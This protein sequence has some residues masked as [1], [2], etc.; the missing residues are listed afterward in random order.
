MVRELPCQHIFHPECV[1]AFLSTS[2]S[3]CPMCKKSALPRGYCPAIITNA[4]VRRERVV[5]RIRERV[6][7]PDHDNG[8]NDPLDPRTSAAHLSRSNNTTFSGFYGRLQHFRH[9]SHTQHRTNPDLTSEFGQPMTDILPAPSH[10]S[11][12]DPLSSP[13]SPPPS[14]LPPNNN[15]NNNN[16][17]RERA[18][19]RALAMLGPQPAPLDPDAEEARRTPAWKRTVRKVFPVGR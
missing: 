4:M 8:F 18:R 9:H 12:P 16:N 15:N 5:R 10:P 7:G 14:N 3:L 17:R 11:N 13:S 19:Q 1:D 2:S 6:D